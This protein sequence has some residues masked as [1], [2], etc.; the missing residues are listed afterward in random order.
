[1]PATTSEID[2]TVA[3]PKPNTLR[4]EHCGHAITLNLP[5]PI[6]VAARAMKDFAR[7]HGQCHTVQ[8]FVTEGATNASTN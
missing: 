2:N 7:L 5:L 4:C 6:P 3:G 1:M 8:V